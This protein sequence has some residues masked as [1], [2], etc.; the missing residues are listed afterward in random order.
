M[1]MRG[2]RRSA[3]A[4][5]L[6]LGIVLSG[7][8]DGDGV[9]TGSGRPGGD[10]GAAGDGG[11]AGSDSGEDGDVAAAC[12]RLISDAEVSGITGIPDL[13]FDPTGSVV[14][15][16]NNQV[17]PYQNAA[18][19]EAIV[20]VYTAGAY[21]Q[22]FMMAFQAARQSPNPAAV[23][24]L[25]REAVW[26]DVALQLLVDLGGKGL[27]V[28]FVYRGGAFDSIAG[29]RDKAVAIADLVSART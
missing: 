18:G 7:C 6:A 16:P 22:G 3:L 2:V 4:A 24:G 13:A 11:D 10:A 5:V 9:Q 1:V 26:V 19:V 12:Q 20:T 27:E 28:R 25:G 23:S 8:G 21:D 14:D 17:C 15:I 29:P